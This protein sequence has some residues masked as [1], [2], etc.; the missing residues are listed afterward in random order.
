MVI[1]ATS[2][3]AN[4]FVLIL[5]HRN[6]KIKPPM[7]KWVGYDYFILDCKINK[8]LLFFNYILGWCFGV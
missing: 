1:S 4:V 2:I 8:K 5:H 7:P 3:V 6:V